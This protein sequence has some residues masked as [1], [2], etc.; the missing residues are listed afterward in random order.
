[1]LLVANSSLANGS[2]ALPNRTDAPVSTRHPDSVIIAAANTYGSGPDR[3][4]VGR[5][6]LDTAFLNRFTCTT[7]AVD[8][9]RELESS[10]TGDAHI[11][12]RVWQ[13]RDKVAELK[14]RR[15][16]GTRDL[17]A[18]VRLVKGA[19]ETLDQALTAFSEG[20]TH[21]ERVKCGI[22]SAA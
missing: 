2:L 10:L 21:D 3:Q 7:I 8:Y 1:V 22:R 15:V 18:I 17:L 19:G 13:I 4:Y 9:D 6:Q 16:V 12:A 20:W 14:L 11:C 5:N